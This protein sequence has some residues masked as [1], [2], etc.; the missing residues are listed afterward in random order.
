MESDLHVVVGASG[1]T[2][3][4]LVRELAPRSSGR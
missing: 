4:A 1:G 2:G 3:A